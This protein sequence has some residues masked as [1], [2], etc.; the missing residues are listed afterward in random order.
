M[1]DT[2]PVCSQSKGRS[3][4]VVQGAAVAGKRKAISTLLLLLL[5]A[6]FGRG[7]AGQLRPSLTDRARPIRLS[8]VGMSVSVTRPRS[9]AFEEIEGDLPFLVEVA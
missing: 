7:C 1:D 5:V 8:A 2:D 9:C 6:G 3:W 4:S